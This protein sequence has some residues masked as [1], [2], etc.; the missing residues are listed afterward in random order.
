MIPVP[1]E[2]K[3]HKVFKA[4]LELLVLKVRKAS[5]ERPDL[6]E[7]LEP[8]VLKDHKVR[9]V[10]PERQVRKESRATKVSQLTR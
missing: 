10:Q 3:V 9:L 2:L 5:K 7:R 4:K 6:P 1:L 8:Q